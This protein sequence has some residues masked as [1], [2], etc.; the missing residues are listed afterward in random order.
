MAS[1]EW[2]K[3][4]LG[5]FF[6]RLYVSHLA[7]CIMQLRTC[8]WRPLTTHKRPVVCIHRRL[9]HINST[10]RH[11]WGVWL[12]LPTKIHYL[13]C[14]PCRPYHLIWTT[15]RPVFCQIRHSWCAYKLLRCL[16]V[17]IRKFFVDNGNDRTD[18]FTPCAWHG[19]ITCMIMS[20]PY[21]I[22]VIAIC[23]C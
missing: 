21:I 20:C 15:V 13:N 9:L 1:A 18:Y 2:F 6:A 17:Q 7:A 11:S 23:W 14:D 16:N 10:S 8:C 19:V 22:C 5:Q 3:A 4:Y 12:S